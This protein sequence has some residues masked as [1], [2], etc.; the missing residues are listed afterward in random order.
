M[1]MRGKRFDGELEVMC[2]VLR[3]ES[4]VRE[5]RE[6]RHRAAPHAPIDMLRRFVSV[7]TAR[8]A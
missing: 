4:L 8:S 2:A 7:S 1:E 6:S 3:D 5:T